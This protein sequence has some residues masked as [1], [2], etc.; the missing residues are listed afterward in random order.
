MINKINKERRRSVNATP[1]MTQ[2]QYLVARSPSGPQ[3][4]TGRTSQHGQFNH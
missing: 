2:Q 4:K 3:T 1:H